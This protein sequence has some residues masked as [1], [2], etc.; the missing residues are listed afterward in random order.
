MK[1]VSKSWKTAASARRTPKGPRPEKK[2]LHR[3]PYV[4]VIMLHNVLAPPPC[5]LPSLIGIIK[6]AP[7]KPTQDLD[8]DVSPPLKCASGR[9]VRFVEVEYSV[10][11][12]TRAGI[13][14]LCLGDCTRQAVGVL[15]PLDWQKVARAGLGSVGRGGR[16]ALRPR[17]NPIMSSWCTLLP[18]CVDMTTNLD[19]LRWARPVCSNDRHFHGHCWQGR[20]EM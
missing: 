3:N 16:P 17:R 14:L 8:V 9:E 11:C 1:K 18:M 2:R 12:P 6:D 4:L 15:D 7:Q 5:H 20:V 13:A 10:M 19:K